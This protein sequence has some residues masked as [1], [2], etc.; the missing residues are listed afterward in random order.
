M[1]IHVQ[2][3][4]YLNLDC[5]FINIPFYLQNKWSLAI[6]IENLFSHIVPDNHCYELSVLRQDI[7]RN[8]KH[9]NTVFFP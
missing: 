1:T 6:H 4:I 9:K 2:M 8:M 7:I 3:A 5:Y